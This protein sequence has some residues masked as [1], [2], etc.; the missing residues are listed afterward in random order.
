MEC[1]TMAG[2]HKKYYANLYDIEISKN[3]NRD[4]IAERIL[5]DNNLNPDLYLARNQ[6]QKEQIQSK[7][8]ELEAATTRNQK[9]QQSKGQSNEPNLADALRK[10]IDQ[11]MKRNEG[12]FPAAS[13][14]SSNISKN[15]FTDE[16]L[17]PIEEH[18][19]SAF[20]PNF[21]NQKVDNEDFNSKRRVQSFSNTNNI[22]A[23]GNDFQQGNFQN[24]NS[25]L[26]SKLTNGNPGINGPSKPASKFSQ[27]GMNDP[28]VDKPNPFQSNQ[29]TKN[30]M[31]QNFP[32]SQGTMNPILFPNVKVFSPNNPFN[33]EN[34]KKI[35]SL[36]NPFNQYPQNFPQNVPSN[37]SSKNSPNNFQNAPGS[38]NNLPRGQNNLGFPSN[39]SSKNCSTKPN[40]QQNT[41]SQ[42]NNQ[43]QFKP[44]SMA[45]PRTETPKPYFNPNP[46]NNF[47]SVGVGGKRP[48]T[49]I[50][51]NMIPGSV[52]GS[53]N[54]H[55]FPNQNIKCPQ[56]NYPM[57]MPSLTRT[58][59]INVPDI[60]LNVSNAQEQLRTDFPREAK[61]KDGSNPYFIPIVVGSNVILI[62]LVFYLYT[63][64]RSGEGIFGLGEVESSSY[65]NVFRNFRGPSINAN[66]NIQEMSQ[67]AFKFSTFLDFK[68]W[69]REI[70]HKL[71]KMV[72]VDKMK[73]YIPLL[74]LLI[75]FY[76]IKKYLDH[77]KLIKQ[78]AKEV[79]E[80]LNE[81][82]EAN[83]NLPNDVFGLF[84]SE[85][86]K[87]FS[88]KFG[89]K[90]EDFIKNYIQVVKKLC[91][92]QGHVKEMQI[93]NKLGN[94]EYLWYYNPEI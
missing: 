64:I 22:F 33:P 65:P 30:Q 85:I 16:N 57:T 3:E 35:P 61:G 51:N 83:K 18:N 58:D 21:G 5:R 70:I 43:E 34:L 76:F 90:V 50:D 11:Q 7:K 2:M 9:G 74:V 27:V 38:V 15:F 77:K 71:F 66:L 86:V 52:P 68:V 69:M 48:R 88:A 63:K 1:E 24:S 92:Q 40:V 62:A 67:N 54:I 73:Y 29:S 59:P 26:T 12:T 79:E 72:I 31:G 14:V 94:F 44:Q 60:A 56:N 49:D 39:Q 19:T 25:N 84:E 46:Q 32:Q 20:L 41:P 13:K 91:K 37:L 55:L 89:I 78:I 42:F 10:G 4:K 47:N 36:P 17:K 80:K 53:K 6:S 45:L 23:S 8:Q 28:Q 93:Q 75:A 82:Y 87:I 81:V